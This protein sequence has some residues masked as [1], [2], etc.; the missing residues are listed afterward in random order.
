MI[1]PQKA[2][3]AQAQPSQKTTLPSVFDDFPTENRSPRNFVSNRNTEAAE[4]EI[5]TVQQS[6]A[7]KL[8]SDI[9][10]LQQDY[11]DRGSDI[12]LNQPRPSTKTVVGEAL[13]PEWSSDRA[14]ITSPQQAI[15]QR[16]DNRQ[17][18]LISAAPSLSLIHI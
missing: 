2:A 12:S 5:S 13:N 8:K 16:L 7:D 9:V 14:P 3:I 6:H 10:T 17:P 15:E 18:E 4:L 11:S 1:I